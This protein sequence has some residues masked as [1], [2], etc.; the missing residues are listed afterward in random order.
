MRGAFPVSLCCFVLTLSAIAGADTKTVAG[1]DDLDSWLERLD[2]TAELYRDRALSFTCVESIRWDQKGKTGRH[3]FGYVVTFDEEHRF[4]DYRTRVRRPRRASAPPRVE[5]ADYG[6]PAYLR[7]AYLWIFIFREERHRFHRYAI[8]GEGWLNG[9]PVVVLSFKPLPP[10]RPQINEWFGTAWVDRET[11]QLL[12]VVAHRPEDEETLHELELH[13]AGEAVSS[14]VYIVEQVTTE[15]RA[16]ARGL[17]FPS[18]VELRRD[19]H[20]FLRGLDQF[21]HDKKLIL[22]TEQKYSS[23]QFFT[24]E[25]EPQLGHE[26]QVEP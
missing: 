19:R 21:D 8:L 16:E 15:F 17:R 24:T 1:G 6:V 7:S 12:K 14:W 20:G 2:R 25:A 26:E 5:P 18:R 11:A 22:S 10:F 23:Y 4:E 9:R 3:K 13:K